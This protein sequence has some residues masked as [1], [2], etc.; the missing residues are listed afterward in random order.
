MAASGAL[1]ALAALSRLVLGAGLTVLQPD[2]PSSAVK[3]SDSP[4]R[5]VITLIE[6]MKTQ[7]EKD[8]TEDEA[9]Y[10]KYMCWCKKNEQ[11]KN[12]AIAAAEQRIEQLTA[13]LQEL[14]A[15]ESRLKTEIAGLEADIAED[16]EALATAIAVREKEYAAFQAEEAD[17]KETRGLLAESVQVLSKV[18]L[19]QTGGETWTAEGAQAKVALMQLRD[20]VSRPDFQSMMKKDLFE[21]LGSFADS[22][23]Q[24]TFLPR[25]SASFVSQPD[26]SDPNLLPWEKTDEQKGMEAK[27]TGLEGAAAGAKSYN[28]RSGR[29]LGI[30][31]EMKDETSRDLAEAQ[32][33]D[34]RAEVAFQN[35]R[36]AKLDEIAVATAQ[37]KRKEADLADTITQA[38][39]A[40]EDK[41]A[42]EEALAADQKFLANLL[43]DCKFEDEEYQKRKKIRSEEIVAIT[44]TLRIL[45]AD[46]ARSLYE[47]TVSFVQLGSS[48]ARL[49]DTRAER[50]MQKIAAV[51]RKHKNW[52]LVS[53]AVRTE[54]DAFVKV[55]Q[56]MDK[57]LAQL[58]Q[59]Q[60]EEYA[61]WETCKSDIDKAEDDIK[62]GMETKEDLDE[63]HRMLVNEIETLSREIS[64]LQ[65]EDTDMQV[66]LKEA[67]E[68]R[69][70]QNGVYQTSVMD[71]RATTNILN[72]ALA[73]LTAFYMQKSML[74]KDDWV[75]GPGRAIAPPPSK[76]KNFKKSGGAGAVIQLLMKV[77][78]NSE[79]EEKQLDMDE[80]NS[81][82]L[83]AEY[84]QVTTA[85][86]EANRASVEQK[87]AR[88]AEAR[89]GK[90]DTEGDQLANDEELARLTDLLKA[91]HLECDYVLKYF[92]VRQQARAEEMDAITDAKAV[93]SGADFK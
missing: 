66:A 38:A 25:K 37:K 8:A 44:E 72:K 28:S 84:V 33:N 18:Q 36:A 64:Q 63:K 10:D 73:G 14:A 74:Q 20:K 68:Q 87:Q 9:A 16:Q 89:S 15:R 12:A 13:L 50:A 41:E 75:A 17:L 93:L 54:L 62:V 81:Q 91:Y 30:L 21:V 42:T 88:R 35:L 4:I 2:E 45:T 46:D 86:I 82:R 31:S 39:E 70:A 22:V 67:G 83:Y 6:E 79:V 53:L 19:V 32:R 51:A 90:A 48:R 77:I 11:A 34:F 56:A 59:Q 1:F 78:E 55:K 80:Q 69:K 71:Q 61:K 7:A 3:A 5:M 58:Q 57:M 65:Q 85:S 43:K 24:G 92:D 60:K 76:G 23:P 40:K 52:A 49:H 27:P 29:I 47:T 26:L